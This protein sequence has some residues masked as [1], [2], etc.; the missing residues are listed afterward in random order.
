MPEALGDDERA[1]LFQQRFTAKFIGTAWHER[2]SSR[3]DFA[4]SER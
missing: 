2:E 1:Q 3:V 4:V